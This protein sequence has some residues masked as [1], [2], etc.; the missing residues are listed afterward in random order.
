TVEIPTLKGPEQLRIPEG[1]Q[2]GQVFRLKGKGIKDL[3]S[4]RK[5]DLFVRVHVQTPKN[6]TKE[7]K[8]RLREFAESMGENLDGVDKSILEKVKNFIH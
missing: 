3:Y 4:H 8:R 7:Q 6:L 5:G 1:T 2:P